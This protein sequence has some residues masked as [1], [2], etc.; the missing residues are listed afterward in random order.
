MIGAVTVALMFAADGS[1]N[2]GQV[3]LPAMPHVLFYSSCFNEN[4]DVAKNV[5]NGQNIAAEQLPVYCRTLRQGLYKQALDAVR[6][7]GSGDM[8]QEGKRLDRIFNT[9]ERNN[10]V[11]SEVSAGAAAE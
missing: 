5:M 8:L 10:P 7:S 3:S 2:M 11:R 4:S 6:S 1:Y 9:I